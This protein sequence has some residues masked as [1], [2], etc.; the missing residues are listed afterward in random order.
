MNHIHCLYLVLLPIL[1]SGCE[2]AASTTPPVTSQEQ[3]SH[4]AA[5]KASY[6]LA[7][8]YDDVV[9]AASLAY[10]LTIAAPEEAGRWKEELA[11]IHFATRRHASCLKI[12]EDLKTNHGSGEDAEVLE[13]QALCHEALGQKEAAYD[14]WALVWHRSGSARHAI[15][16]AGIHFELGQ[17]E[18]ANDVVEDGLAA[19]DVETAVVKLPMNRDE[20]QVVPASAALY[21]LGGLIALQRSRP[22]VEGGKPTQAGIEA[23]RTY[24]RKALEIAPEFEIAKRNLAGLSDEATPEQSEGGDINAEQPGSPTRLQSMTEPSPNKGRD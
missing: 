13:M 16:V 17:Y 10:Q 18:Q 14:C 21:N 6:S 2:K 3:L 5:L 23:A 20:M 22:D 11:K 1:L 24:L 19:D 12:L 8:Q 9:A 15:R 7:S 4:V